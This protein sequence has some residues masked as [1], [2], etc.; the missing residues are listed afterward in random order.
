[1]TSKKKNSI[2]IQWKHWM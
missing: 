1:V 2:R